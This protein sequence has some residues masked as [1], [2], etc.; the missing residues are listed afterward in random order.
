MND[1]GRR[2]APEEM[3]GIYRASKIVVNVSR[4]D[5]PQDANMRCFEA[6]AGGALLIT[7]S[8]SELSALGFEEGSHFIAYREPAEVSD[9]VAHWIRRDSD[10]ETIAGRGRALV[11]SQ[12]TYDERVATIL[13]VVRG[14]IVAPARTWP[15]DR[16]QALRFD[17]FVEH[18]NVPESRRAYRRLI[19]ISPLR[20]VRQLPG[21]LRLGLKVAKRLLR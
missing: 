7:R 3:A 14:G 15:A 9:L 16:V 10:R 17:Y 13:A 4:D 12:H 18:A 5:Y 8:P 21:L 19:S 1:V 2:Y 20:A 11:L 6:M